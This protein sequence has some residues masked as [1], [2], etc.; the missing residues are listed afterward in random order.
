[1]HDAGQPQSICGDGYAKVFMNEYGISIYDRFKDETNCN[2]SM[3]VRHRIID[4]IL[5]QQLLS[6]PNLHVITIGAGLDS[7][8]YRLQ[9]GKWFELDEP[10]VVAYKNERLPQSKCINQLERIPI[11]FC[12]ELIEDKLA[13][14][15]SEEP[16]MIVMEGVCI[17]L[18]KDET[19]KAITPLH[20]LFPNHH[21]V[22]DLVNREMVEKYGRS[23]HEKI[24]GIGTQF[25]PVDY[26][27]K[28]FSANGYRITD[29]V[30]VIERS[31]D[32]GINKIPKWALRCFFSPSVFGNS[33]YVFESHEL[34][35]DLVF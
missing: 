12:A 27:D 10:A 31:T 32:F 22:C 5:H 1:M 28:V 13:S 25:K 18:S 17:Y 33:V 24:E 21:L 16:A 3:L 19:R 29:R 11:N 9:G 14:I 6:N 8:P 15:A 30:S 20:R 23:L 35:S 4:D 7:R 2:A 26:P 34:Y